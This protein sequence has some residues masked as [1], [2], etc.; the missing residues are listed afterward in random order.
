MDQQVGDDARDTVREV[1]MRAWAVVDRVASA[2]RGAP[3][4]GAQLADQARV[5]KQGDAA[6]IERGQ[7]IAIAV[8]L[9]PL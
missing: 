7:R 3:F 6:R 9:R 4:Q 8:R 5:V 2:S 1:V